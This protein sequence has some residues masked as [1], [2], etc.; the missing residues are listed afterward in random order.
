M[1]KIIIFTIIIFSNYLSFSQSGSLS[2][3]VYDKTNNEPIP[4]ANVLIEGTTI[5]STTDL[6]GKFIFK[7]LNPGFV[8]LRVTYVGYKTKFSDDIQIT[9]SSNPYIEIYLEPQ[10]TELETAEV[11]IS[12]FEKNNVSPVSAKTI[13]LSEIES[14]PGSNRDISKVVQSYPGVAFVPSFRN[15][16]I[17]R[18]G[19][20]AEN[21]Y[22]LD[23]VEIPNINHFSTQGSSG[24]ATGIINA[25]LLQSVDFLAGAFPANKNKALSAI[26]DLKMKD[27]NK[28]K[29]KYRISLGASETAFS[30]D[31]P[32]GD[33]SSY[34]LSI[35]RSY[36]QLLFNALGLPFLPTFSDYQFKWK[37]KFNKKSELTI[38]GIGA[39][40]EFALNLGL[41]NPD[42]SQEYILSYLPVN[43]Q[44]SYTTGAVYKYYSDNSL[45]T[46]VL[47]RNMLNNSSYKY[48]ENDDTKPK[49]LDYL[50]Q[51][52]ENKLRLENTRYLDLFRINIG[53]NLEYAKYNNSTKNLVYINNQVVNINYQTDFNLFKYGLFAQ[54]NGEYFN[55][56]L[57]LSA[58]IRTDFNGFNESM[59]NPLNQLSPRLS[60]G[61][62]LRKDLRITANIGRYYR[63]PSYTSMG[64]KNELGILI[65]KENDISYIGV[66]HFILG[67]EYLP[68]ENIQISLEGFYKNYFNFPFSVKDSISIASRGIDFGVVGNEEVKSISKGRAYGLELSSRVKIRSKLNMIFSYTY[69]I[70]EFQDKD[71][72]YTPTAW[73]SRNIIST[74]GTYN[75]AKDWSA[76]FKWRY[77]GGLPYTPYDLETS[78]LISVWSTQGQAIVDY[79]L[80][81]SLRLKPFH[82]L[83]IRVD[84]KFFFPKWSLMLYID[85]QNLYNF[86]VKSQDFIIREK[87]NNGNFITNPNGTRYDLRRIANSSG[88]VLPTIGIMVE[89]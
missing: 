4:F 58:G 76:G 22:Y 38:I 10:A 44:W 79:S 64:Y 36:L 15:D 83:D 87:D 25:D 69:V 17:I 62:E 55:D 16:I 42:P 51:E 35:R 46:L 70:S 30:V 86:Q 33:K 66:D 61:Y 59:K 65:N 18:G 37:T 8:R 68:K 24:G 41:E 43:E 29:A 81:N 57:L 7:S 48:P 89:I 21:T 60:L 56:K 28:E 63:L 40:D 80:L 74:T 85:I 5:G 84:K 9:N 3:A 54:L 34:L 23:G 6:D 82:Q 1:R 45:T 47:S 49:T 52:I 50:S 27:G 72:V 2:G 32:V 73:D 67:S 31:G 26:F 11:T 71:G 12:A 13:S 75:F 53:G 88:T 78:S 20:P 39:L 19:G 77:S 14:N